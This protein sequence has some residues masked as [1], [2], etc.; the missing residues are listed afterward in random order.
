MIFNS[1][2]T[3]QEAQ[4]NNNPWNNVFCI[5]LTHNIWTPFQKHNKVSKYFLILGKT[6]LIKEHWFYISLLMLKVYCLF[7]SIFFLQFLFVNQIDHGLYKSFQKMFGKFLPKISFY[8]NDFHPSRD[9]A[10]LYGPLDGL[11][12]PH[13]LVFTEYSEI[14]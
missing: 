3:S 14:L 4:N 6:K 2:K 8:K 13:G 1:L 10:L 5:V 9:A 11:H 7:F 12:G